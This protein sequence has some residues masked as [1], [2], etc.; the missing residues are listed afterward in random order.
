MLIA[1]RLLAL[2]LLAA[3]SLLTLPLGAAG[4][5]TVNVPVSGTIGQYWYCNSSYQN[6]NCPTMINTGDTVNWVFNGDIYSN[7]TATHCGANCNSP[8]GSPLFNSGVIQVGSYSYQFNTPGTYLYRCQ[9]HTSSMRGTI[10]VAGGVGGQ[11]QLASVGDVTGGD[12]GTWLSVWVGVAA[13]AA[14][15]VVLTGATWFAR[16]RLAES[17]PSR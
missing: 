14:G 13:I 6:G 16:T 9:I 11:A 4:A 8:T 2:V 10:T 5:V 7:H 17:E 3:G 1:T 12:S 15:A